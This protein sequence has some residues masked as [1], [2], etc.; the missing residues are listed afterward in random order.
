VVRRPWPKNGGGGE[1][2]PGL[3]FGPD[4]PSRSDGGGVLA[5]HYLVLG[6]RDAAIGELKNAVKYQPDDKVSAELLKALTSSN[7]N[8]PPVPGM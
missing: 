5:Y 6:S 2:K 7:G 3:P 4:R 8:A 1:L